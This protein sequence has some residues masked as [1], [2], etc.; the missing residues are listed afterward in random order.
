MKNVFRVAVGALA[1]LG[2]LIGLGL[3]AQGQKEKVVTNHVSGPFEVKL[4][5]LPAYDTTE[6]S[7][8]ARMSIDKTYHGDLEGT[9]KGEMLS[10][11]TSVQGSAGYVAIERVS[12]TL[13]G[14]K[15]TFILQHSGTM[16][17]GTPQLAITVVPDSGTGQLAGLTGKMM[18]NIAGGKHSYDLEYTLPEAP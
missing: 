4:N 9:G 6:G 18:I 11:S 3:S 1:G 2:L 15:G 14:R 8:L 13:R 7:N 10:A 5:P 12:G 17:R 16:T